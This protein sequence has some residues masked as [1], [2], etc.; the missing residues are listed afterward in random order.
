M[1]E[2]YTLCVTKRHRVICRVQTGTCGTKRVPL[3]F[4]HRH[5]RQFMSGLRYLMPVSVMINFYNIIYEII[6]TYKQMY[7]NSIYRLWN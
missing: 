2:N 7:A 3:N 1:I 6:Y 4:P 5:S